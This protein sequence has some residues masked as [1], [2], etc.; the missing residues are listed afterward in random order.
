MQQRV[1]SS[2]PHCSEVKEQTE[3]SAAQQKAAEEAAQ[4]RA[5]LAE[6]LSAGASASEAALATRD[7]LPRRERSMDGGGNRGTEAEKGEL[8]YQ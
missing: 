5:E 3:Q 4:Q 7:H 2:L 1:R 8:E 6:R